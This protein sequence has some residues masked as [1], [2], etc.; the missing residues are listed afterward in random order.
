[1]GLTVLRD[2]ILGVWAAFWLYWLLAA[3]GA[4]A[5]RGGRRRPTAG[6]WLILVVL[7]GLRIARPGGAL[8]HDVASGV[9]GAVLF[10][11]GI[12]LAVRSRV[13]LGANWGMP[14]TEKQ[15]PELV[16][17]GPYRLIRHPIY[18]G[19]LLAMLG[20]ALAVSPYA[21]I[22]FVLAGGYFIYSARVEEGIMSQ[23]FPNDYPRYRARTKMLIPF[24][25]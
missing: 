5:S 16:T 9:A 25:L 3:R 14:M 2:C 6:S 8:A 18:T 23:T 15:E 17:Q 19:I 24:V 7:V 22:A 20:T 10:A 1:V 21:L 13:V 4:K 12:A 11:A